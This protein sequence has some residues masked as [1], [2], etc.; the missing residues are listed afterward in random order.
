MTHE[1]PGDPNHWLMTLAVLGFER[2]RPALEGIGAPGGAAAPFPAA[3][4]SFWREYVRGFDDRQNHFPAAL[5]VSFEA[6]EAQGTGKVEALRAWARR[7]YV[8]FQQLV[9]WND[10]AQ[11]FER[12]AGR[13]HRY[14]LV[15]LPLRKQPRS[16]QQSRAFAGMAEDETLER[17]ITRTRASPFEVEVRGVHQRHRVSPPSVRALHGLSFA[18]SRERAHRV[19]REISPQLSAEDR[20]ALRRWARDQAT[21]LHSSAP[22]LDAALDASSSQ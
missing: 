7:Q 1:E 18:L 5:D 9:G 19:W 22:Y 16:P 6:A 10:W 15:P 11:V 4:Q 3:A 8:D 21:A 20:V 12:V 14:P 13:Y 17:A 2:F